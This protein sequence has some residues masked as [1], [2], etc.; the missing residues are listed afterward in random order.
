LGL[1]A[2]EIAALELSDIEWRHGELAV[3]G[4]GNRHERLPLPADVGEA[5]AGYL[6]RGRPRVDHQKVFVRSRAPLEGIDS[7]G[8]NRIVATASARCGVGRVSPH[9]LRHTLASEL[10]GRGA[11]LGEVGQLLRH[12]SASTTAIYA[13]VDHVALAS[14]AQPWPEATR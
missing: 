8:V 5:I 2:C 9:Q 1:R 4:K 6:Q 13:K 10:L 7:T 14:L 12:R 3:R 11:S